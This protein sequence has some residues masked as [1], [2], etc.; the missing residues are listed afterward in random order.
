MNNHKGIIKFFVSLAIS[1]LLSWMVYK[2]ILDFIN[3]SSSALLCS[4]VFLLICFV[5]LYNVI[6]NKVSKFNTFWYGLIS[7]GILLKELN[8]LEFAIAIDRLKQDK[9]VRDYNRIINSKIVYI[10]VHLG[11]LIALC[12]ILLMLELEEKGLIDP[13]LMSL[14]TLILA[15]VSVSFLLFLPVVLFFAYT[16]FKIGKTNKNDAIISILFIV[17]FLSTLAFIFLFKLDLALVVSF[18]IIFLL[19]IGG[20]AT[21]FKNNNDRS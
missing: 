12:G 20:I 16:H 5:T 8:D 2:V 1:V 19:I 13:Q 15:I 3:D 11:I 4:I 7:F 18:D 21:A 9:P 14:I 17:L 6:R 10:I